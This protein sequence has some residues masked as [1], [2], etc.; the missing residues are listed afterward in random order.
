[1]LGEI[2]QI[3]PWVLHLYYNNSTVEQCMS[4]F[5]QVHGWIM[6]QWASGHRQVNHPPPSHAGRAVFVC[7]H[8]L[9]LSSTFCSL[10]CCCWFKSTQELQHLVTIEKKLVCTK[11]PFVAKGHWL[12]ITQI[13]VI[14]IALLMM[15]YIIKQKYN[16]NKHQLE[17][18]W[19]S[20]GSYFYF[21]ID[22]SL[23]VLIYCEGQMRMSTPLLCPSKTKKRE[24]Q[25]TVCISW[26]WTVNYR[27]HWFSAAS[28]WEQHVKVAL[29]LFL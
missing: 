11:L 17:L 23:I 3:S 1:M 14:Y 8:F 22:C 7:C 27:L 21:S 26:L 10:K 25:L 18:S 20:F 19:I 6:R 4:F 15:S 24:K 16:K 13:T 29:N 2:P 9:F 12:C 28:H 5:C